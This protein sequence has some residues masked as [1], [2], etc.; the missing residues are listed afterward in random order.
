MPNLIANCLPVV[1]VPRRAPRERF[2]L[3]VEWARI[4]IAL[5]SQ[6]AKVRAYFYLL[7]LEGPR[8]SEARLMQWAHVDLSAG[9]WH[10]P[11]CK[12]GRSQMLPLSVA[13]CGLLDLLPRDRRF[14]F[15][16][17]PNHTGTKDGPWSRTS[18]FFYWRRI[19]NAA[20]VPDVQIRDLRRT[21]ASWMAIHGENIAVISKVLHHSSLQ[22]TEVYARLDL[23]AV[24][25]ALTR[26]AARVIG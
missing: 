8:M 4:R 21:A 12:N 6:P 23:E 15:H 16:G 10:K 25:S 9:L 19:R 2:L 24:R 17:D 26:H 5:E 22:V 1:K 3:P 7:A 11:R 20:G 18:V 13:A 14:V